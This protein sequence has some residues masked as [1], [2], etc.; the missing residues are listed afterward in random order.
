M[1]KIKDKDGNPIIGQRISE[2]AEVHSVQPVQQETSERRNYHFDVTNLP[3]SA[4]YVDGINRLIQD[5]FLEGRID[6]MNISD[7]SRT[8]KDL[9]EEVNK[10][11]EEKIVA[12]NRIDQLIK[13]ATNG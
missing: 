11:R 7:G 10:L 3:L 12:E 9:Y 13:L 2:I 6:V 5:N 8:F 1:I 4:T